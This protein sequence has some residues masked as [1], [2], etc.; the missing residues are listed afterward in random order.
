MKTN[1]RGSV[2]GLG[3]ALVF[4]AAPLVLLVPLESAAQVAVINTAPFQARFPQFRIPPGV[5]VNESCITVPAGKRLTLEHVSGIAFQLPPNEAIVWFEVET[6]AANLRGS[7]LLLPTPTAILIGLATFVTSQQVRLY[8]DGGTEVCFRAFGTDQTG[9]T[10]V[11][12]TVSGY[13]VDL[14]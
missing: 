6:L 4:V 12:A 14:P 8:A 3:V 10:T 1:V 13:L 7:H 5:N 11:D 9:V 2:L